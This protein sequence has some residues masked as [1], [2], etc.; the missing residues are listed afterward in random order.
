M[1]NKISTIGK[2]WLI[3]LMVLA[4]VG[5]VTNLM[6]IGNGIIYLI[7]A[8]MCAGELFGLIYLMRGKG[9]IYL[10][11][12]GGCYL[13]NAVLTI[14]TGTEDKTTSYYV[15]FVLGIVINV[16]LTYLACKNTFEK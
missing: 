12:Y 4:A 14:I 8:L 13:V 15:G 3:F 2:I 16:G 11:I 7:S 6:A 1:S 10:F 9:S 5:I